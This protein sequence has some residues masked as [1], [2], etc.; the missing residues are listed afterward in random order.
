M[1]VA[2]GVMGSCSLEL[3]AGRREGYE[4]E[5]Q[6]EMSPWANIRTL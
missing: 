4:I 3:L 5:P 2:E 1:F 6:A